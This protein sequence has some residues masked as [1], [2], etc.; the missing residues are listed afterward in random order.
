ME[1][2]PRKHTQFITEL[3]CESHCV[4]VLAIIIIIIVVVVVVAA[5]DDCDGYDDVVGINVV[6]YHRRMFTTSCIDCLCVL[7]VVII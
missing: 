1:A 5:A 3:F 6:C 4:C 2:I 7:I